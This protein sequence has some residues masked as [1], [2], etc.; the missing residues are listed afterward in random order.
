MP[1]LVLHAQRAEGPAQRVAAAVVD[2]VVQCQKARPLGQQTSRRNP[3][4]ECGVIPLQEA[5]GRANRTAVDLELV[6]EG[7]QAAAAHGFGQGQCTFTQRVQ[8]SRCEQAKHQCQCHVGL[9]RV[10]AA[11][12]QETGQVRGGGVRRV[13]LGHRRDEAQHAEVRGHAREEEFP[14]SLAQKKSPTS[15]GMRCPHPGRSWNRLRRAT[16]RVP[17]PAGEGGRRRRRRRGEFTINIQRCSPPAHP[18]RF[19]CTWSSCRPRSRAW[20]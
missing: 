10:N 17:P 8:T 5:N 1:G 4:G 20:S 14:G 12:A 3:V 11:R 19:P 2:V 9:G 6:E 13:E 18:A 7:V 16:D 15:V